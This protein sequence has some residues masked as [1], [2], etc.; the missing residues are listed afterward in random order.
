MSMY[1][2]VPVIRLQEG[3][4]LMQGWPNLRY[5]VAYFLRA[6]QPEG[7]H[8]LNMSITGGKKAVLEY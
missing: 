7:F 8:S 3:G 2:A 4:Q 1:C 6:T 5:E